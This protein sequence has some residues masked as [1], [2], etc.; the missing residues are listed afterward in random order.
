MAMHVSH[1]IKEVAP[2]MTLAMS[3]KAAEMR[4]AGIDVA[5]LSAGEPD[6]PTP[7]SVIA[8]VRGDFE[9]GR[10]TYTPAA[11][12]PAVRDAVGAHFGA[13]FGFPI[14]RESVVV[15]CGAK[16]ALY[17]ALQ[18]LC[19]D[20]DEVVFA[21]PYW[22]S[23]PEMAR[24]AGARFVTVPT[25]ADDGFRL[26][27]DALEAAITERT[28]V[29]ILNSPSNPTGAILSRA[30]LEAVVA[31]AL[32]HEQLWIVSD[33]IY[34]QLYY[35]PEP[36]TSLFSFGP[37]VRERTIVVNGVSKSYAMTGW[38]IGYAIG[39][40]DVIK[41]MTR[42]QSHET[43]NANTL[44]QKATLAALTGDQSVLAERRRIFD[45]RRKLT[46]AGVRA[47]PGWTCAE[48]EGAFY[49]FPRVDALFGRTTPAGK[50]ISGSMNLSTT[51][52]EEAHVATVPGIAFGDDAYIRLSYATSVDRIEEGLRR[53]RAFVG[54]MR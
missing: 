26:D 13:R 16:H 19:D 27:P 54:G 20:G 2:S 48:P 14:A 36:P 39:P 5:D 23:Y 49:V 11:G 7:P 44:A 18:V 3:G 31:V 29:L 9:A 51:L 1:R 12:M 52:L 8:A 45:E 46:V 42:I 17:L 21:S 53:I 24:L 32:R 30:N 38:R 50:I 10:L 41:L 28:R 33:E 34:D 35:T 47:V 37:E 6:F 22:V 25:R 40:G 43:S 15:T 4:Q